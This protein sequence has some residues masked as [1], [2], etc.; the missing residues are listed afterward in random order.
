M[1]ESPNET[2]AFKDFLLEEIKD[3][4]EIESKEEVCIVFC[5]YYLGGTQHI[6]IREN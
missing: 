1:C 4:I 3:E 2:I 5:H 6:S